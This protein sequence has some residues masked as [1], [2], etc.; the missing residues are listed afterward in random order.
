MV[1]GLELTVE[2]LGFRLGAL[3]SAQP[4]GQYLKGNQHISP[5]VVIL[6]RIFRA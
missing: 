2:G 5:S 4:A 3:A 6:Y 1:E